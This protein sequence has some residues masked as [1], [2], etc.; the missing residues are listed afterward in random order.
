MVLIPTPFILASLIRYHENTTPTPINPST[1]SR[2]VESIAEDFPTSKVT[3]LAFELGA[4]SACIITSMV[5][6]LMGLGGRFLRT[7]DA[8]SRRKVSYPNSADVEK[9]QLNGVTLATVRSIIGRI[10]SVALPL[11][12]AAKLGANRVALIMLVALAT[13]LMPIDGKSTDFTSLRKWKRLLLSQRWTLASISLQIGCDLIGLTN[14]SAMKSS[15]M[16]YVALGVS[17][18][19]L[20]P[21][22]PSTKPRTSAVA[23]GDP[24]S[25]SADSAVLAKPEVIKPTD[26][27]LSPLICTNEDTNLTLVAGGLLAVLSC[28]IPFVF[29]SGAGALHPNT[30]G[31]LFL[32]A[33][34]TVLS[35]TITQPQSI[36]H[37]KGL[38]LIF[39]AL[40][41]ALVLTVLHHASWTSSVYQGVFISISFAA[42]KQDTRSLFSKSAHSHHETHSQHHHDNPHIV[43]HDHPSRF[44]KALLRLFQHWPILHSILAEKDSRRIFY[45]MT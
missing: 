2:L 4:L 12:A 7:T 31:W 23:S 35:Y 1:T 37:S 34:T 32:S 6:L 27:T 5:L 16:G 19:A 30:L 36:R 10:L 8:P 24:Q 40:L 22:F 18:L 28:I 13:N 38:G 43:H 29:Q 26:I 21:P 33:C 14:Q 9:P 45:F 11:Y 39:G 25:T 17:A 42:I 44:S 20:P 3:L 41:C 15:W